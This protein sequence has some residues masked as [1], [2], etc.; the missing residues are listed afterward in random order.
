[1]NCILKYY[2][3]NMYFLRFINKYMYYLVGLIL[4]F[5]FLNDFVLFDF[6]LI[7]FEYVVELLMVIY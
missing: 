2:E 5:F 6:K 7:K 4:K 1:M 3:S